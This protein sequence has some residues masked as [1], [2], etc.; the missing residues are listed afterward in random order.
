MS[1]ARCA[2]G[3]GLV[4]GGDERVELVDGLGGPC[5]QNDDVVHRTSVVSATNH[6]PF[7]LWRIRRSI[8][9]CAWR[10][11][12]CTHLGPRVVSC[13]YTDPTSLTSQGTGKCEC[14]RRTPARLVPTDTSRVFEAD[15]STCVDCSMTSKSTGCWGSKKFSKKNNATSADNGFRD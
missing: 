7:M 10:A 15:K 4:R 6:V 5:L 13:Q 8:H 9:C 1:R 3:V 11:A 2:P 12:S 14:S